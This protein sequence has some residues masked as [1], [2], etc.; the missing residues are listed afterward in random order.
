MGAPTRARYL[1]RKNAL[2]LW[3]LIPAFTV[4]ISA[5]AALWVGEYLATGR[6]INPG[7]VLL[8]LIKGTS[9]FDQPRFMGA[10][11]VVA[12]LIVLGLFILWVRAKLSKPAWVD[13]AAQH[14]ASYKELS[15]LSEKAAH[16]HGV[17]LGVQQG[18]KKQVGLALGALVSSGRQLYGT[19]E[20][21]G[22]I[23]A[24]PRTGKSSSYSIPLILDAPGAVVATE[25]KRGVCD[26]TRAAR[27][28]VGRVFVFDPQSVVGEPPTW[29]WNP[30]STVTNG[31]EANA[32]AEHFAS[33]SRAPEAGPPDAFFHPRAITLL[34][35]FFLAAATGGYTLLDVQ[36]WLAES[37][38]RESQPWMVLR[39][40]RYREVFNELAGLLSAEPGEKS[41]VFS[42]AQT[43]TACL[44]D[45]AIAQWVN[46]DPDFTGTDQREHFNPDLFIQGANTLYSLSRET[47][48]SAA[49]LVTALTVAVCD[50]GQRL[51]RTSPQGRLAVPLI[52][53]LD[54]AA[55][56]CRWK[57]LPKLYS[58]FGSQGILL[59]TILQSYPQGVGVWGE[60]GMDALL[61][62]AN[63][64]IYA[65]GNK[66][67]KLL[68]TLVD[69]IG[70][71]YYT[72]PGTPASKGSP[73]GRAQEH[74]AKIFDAAELQAL[75]KGRAILLSSGNRAAL[76]RTV[77]WM[78]GPHKEAVE[79]SVKLHD[80]QAEQ[81]LENTRREL[82][83]QHKDPDRVGVP[84]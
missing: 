8:D 12:A 64:T 25:N 21:V 62:A 76:L 44:A 35:A 68:T 4:V 48:G 43:M 82:Q 73:R 70:N 47:S 56:V 22:L 77:P 19:F 55:N 29:W 61:S 58:H 66:P 52:V 53:V 28:A 1:R 37:D 46:P 41:G 2:Q 78:K 60:L 51:A 26:H 42:T 69:S 17:R 15:S 32:L 34:K 7:Q 14:M 10:G 57:D 80:P 6:S 36:R 81:T 65:G 40:S 72:T 30:L 38:K 16:A 13:V 18:V 74:E 75:P 23:F 20:D 49:P 31:T 79:A 11:L 63:W 71:Y 5:L 3:L 33:G 59:V 45:Q 27:A 50:A 84:V 67:G 54:E 24:G 9:T 83:A 39:D